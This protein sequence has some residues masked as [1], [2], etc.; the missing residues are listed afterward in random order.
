MSSAY[1]RVSAC[2]VMDAERV[3]DISVVEPAPGDTQELRGCGFKCQ[4]VFILGT[5]ATGLLRPS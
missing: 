3:G 4:W 1:T 2:A 5:R